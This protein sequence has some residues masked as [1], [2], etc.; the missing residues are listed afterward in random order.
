M[1]ADFVTVTIHTTGQCA[2]GQYLWADIQATVPRGLH[3]S[4]APT[5]TCPTCKGR[6]TLAG[7]VVAN[8]Q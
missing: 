4:S 8:P 6:A 3:A 5:V 2:C 1:P 7:A